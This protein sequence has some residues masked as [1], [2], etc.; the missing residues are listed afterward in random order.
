MLPVDPILPGPRRI[1]TLFLAAASALCLLCMGCNSMFYYPDRINHYPP[2]QFKIGYKDYFFR[3]AQGDTLHGRLHFHMPGQEYK[4]LFVVFH[5]NAQNLTAHYLGY[6]WVLKQGYDEFI[7]DYPGYGL[8]DG[9]A[10]RPGTVSAGKAALSLVSDSLLPGKPG[11]LII[12]GSSLGGAVMMRV[13]PDWPGKSRTDLVI[14]ESTL[15]AYRIAARSAM[16]KQW[17][18]W[19]LVPF[20]YLL[21]SDSYSPEP[22]IPKISPTP[23]LVLA[24]AQDPVVSPKL[25]RKVFDEAKEPKWYWL[26]DSCGHTQTFKLPANRARLLA[27]IDSLHSHREDPYVP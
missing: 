23:M 17:I 14:A 4:G 12:V 10:T 8:S 27:L 16:A 19:P 20:T 1:L 7:F 11:R 21:I 6:A 15:P 24:C 9:K 25:T 5:G 2:E 26:S 13:F 18:S 22:Y 3:D